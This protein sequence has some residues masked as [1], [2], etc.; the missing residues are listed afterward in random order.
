MAVAGV[1][2]EF[3]EQIAFL[4]RKVALPT[5]KWDDLRHGAH[6]RAASIAG[7]TNVALI[8][9]VYRALIDHA[10]DYEAF[11]ANFD[12]LIEAAGWAP[13]GRGDTETQQ[14]AWRARLIYNTNMR[15]SYMAG[16]YEQMTDPD[17]LRMRPWWRYRHNFARHPRKHHLAL[18][19]LVLAATNPW[20]RV[21]YPPN[22][23]GCHCDVESLS[24]ADLR[25]MGR[26]GPDPVPAGDP[27][28]ATDPRTGQP[29][30][31]WPGID[32]GWEYNVGLVSITGLVPR[33]LQEPLP[34]YAGP[35]APL[36]RPDRALPPLPPARPADEARLMP[37]GLPDE[38]YVDA[39]LSEFGAARG[40][41]GAWRDPSGGVVTIGEEMFQQRDPDGNVLRWKV[42]KLG[43]E[44]YV[45]LMADTI[46]DPDEIW[47]DW[48][49]TSSG[50]V[51]RRAYVRRVALPN[52]QAIFLRYQWT[53]AGWTGITA[54]DATDRYVGRQRRGAL[55]YRRE[56]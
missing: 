17:M 15:T 36:P 25:R 9:D 28:R 41:P 34:A 33:E 32:R 50:A 46:R 21:Y 2:L 42:A 3:A 44:R 1:N 38:D 35:A 53:A 40:K 52:G 56:D 18:D 30:L 19:G 27:V 47:V 14:R 12:D 49:E 7:V 45:R 20:W 26:S 24:D 37:A 55:L 51:L 10:G 5:E 43:R 23:W 4:R 29:E 13:R 11:K 31:R 54:F 16:R 8:E 6:V 22:G 39:F 48:A